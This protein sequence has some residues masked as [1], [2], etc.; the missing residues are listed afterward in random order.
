VSQTN[1]LSTFFQVSGKRDASGFLELSL[2]YAAKIAKINSIYAFDLLEGVISHKATKLGIH[3]IRSIVDQQYLGNIN[4][5]PTSTITNV[6][7]LI[8]NPSLEGLT[9]LFK[10]GERATWPQLDL[11]KRNTLISKTLRQHLKSLKEKEAQLLGDENALTV[12]NG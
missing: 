3:K 12:F 8:A 9:K 6:K 7:Q 5:Q 10:S 2:R 11:I 4:I 1:P